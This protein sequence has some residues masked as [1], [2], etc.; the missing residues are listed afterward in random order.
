MGSILLAAQR[1]QKLY[2][3]SVV[4]ASAAS[5]QQKFFLKL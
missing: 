1:N 4:A 3:Q 2:R 5:L